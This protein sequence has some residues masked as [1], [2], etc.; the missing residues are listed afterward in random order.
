MSVKKQLPSLSKL[1]TVYKKVPE[2][3]LN[4]TDVDSYFHHNILDIALI[5]NRIVRASKRSNIKIFALK[6]FQF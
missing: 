1:C 3:F 6:L 2:N 4:E 5:D